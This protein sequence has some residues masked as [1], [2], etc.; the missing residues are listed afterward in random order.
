MKYLLIPLM[1][2]LA[3]SKI[4]LQS[5][6]SK[7]KTLGLLDSVFYNF[8]MFSTV[9]ILFI[10]A[11]FFESPSP[12]TYLY[13]IIAGILS[14][15]FQ[16]S[17]MLAF[18]YGKP[19]LITTVNNF[20]MFI[21]IAVSCIFFDDSFGVLKFIALILAAISI[22]LIT[23]K[24]QRNNQRQNRSAIWILFT[25][26]AFLCNGFV[27]TN[28]KIYAHSVESIDVFSFVAVTYITASLVSLIP[29][30]ILRRRDSQNLKKSKQTIVSASLAALFLGVFQCVSTYAASIID[31]VILYSVYNVGVNLLFVFVR[32]VFFGERLSRKQIVGVFIAISSIVFMK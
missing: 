9:A 13:G 31:G 16:L 25:A 19:V 10:P 6:Y 26:L 27:S 7:T 2:I 22:V 3:T 28:Q 21:P 20:S 29:L 24:E 11:L 12:G 32:M 8:I 15:G 5:H 23:S 1:C 4:S 14:V 17:Y 18:S 30:I